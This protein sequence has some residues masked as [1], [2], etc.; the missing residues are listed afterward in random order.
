[1]DNWVRKLQAIT[2]SSQSTLSSIPLIDLKLYNPFMF[3]LGVVIRSN[4]NM[5][6]VNQIFQPFILL[7]AG[8]LSLISMAFFAIL[9]VPV[10]DR[11][12]ASPYPV[13][14]LLQSLST[15]KH[16][17]PT[18]SRLLASPWQRDNNFHCIDEIYW[19]KSLHLIYNSF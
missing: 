17:L 2:S 14:F 3:I 1:M 6:D 5:Q 13:P 19:Y 4:D 8:Y 16:W 15:T 11:A 12:C 10:R 18:Y 7:T 9:W